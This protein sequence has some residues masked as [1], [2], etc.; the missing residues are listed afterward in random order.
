[1]SEPNKFGPDVTYRKPDELTPYVQN[2]KRHSSAQ[3]DR[4]AG[5]IARFGFDQP[6]VVDANGVIIK[7]HARREAAR[8]LKMEA[9]PVIVRADL[10]EHEMM[11]A[12]IADNRVAE[13]QEYDV[14][15]LQL[16]LGEL[17]KYELDIAALVA[18]VVPRTAQAPPEAPSSGPR[19]DE[20]RERLRTHLMFRGHELPMSAETAGRLGEAI[21]AYADERGVLH[22]F[23]QA[24]LDAFDEH[25]REEGG[26]VQ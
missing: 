23:I 9:V 10:S 13:G 14:E 25:Q 19:E 11:A 1:M 7:G 12:R 6:I 15:K 17:E 4:L 8:R 2:A 3:I 16:E 20:R 24:L 5:I 26:G 18:P 21:E 22:G